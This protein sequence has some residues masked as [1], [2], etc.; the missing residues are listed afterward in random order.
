MKFELCERLREFALTGK[1]QNGNENDS[2]KR[3]N[4]EE[5]QRLIKTV[6]IKYIYKD[7]CKDD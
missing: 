3:D 6:K 5:I 2:D 4:N 7:E 1:S